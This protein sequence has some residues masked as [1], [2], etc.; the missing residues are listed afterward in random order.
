MAGIFIGIGYSSYTS[1]EFLTLGEADSLQAQAFSS[2]WP[3]RT[4]YDS[5]I[6]P[7]RFRYF[8]SN[9]AVAIVDSLGHITTLSVGETALTVSAAGM[10]SPVIRLAVSPKVVALVAEP[11]TVSARVGETFA[12]SVK[13]F[14][15]AGRSTAGVIFNAGLDTTYWALTSLPLEGSWKLHT[16]I[17][18]HFQAKVAGRVRLVMT[19]QNHRAE[20][21]F[22]A[23]VPVTISP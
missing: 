13:A 21:R 7:T 23:I 4:I 10:T 11:D 2:G 9:P 12:V 3:S 6:E 18:L 5:S 14:D 15:S 8:S 19:V 17:T 20:S 1:D 22:Q 16:P